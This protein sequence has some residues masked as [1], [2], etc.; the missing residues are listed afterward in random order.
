MSERKYNG[1]TNYATWNVK[2]WMDNDGSDQHW[3]DRAQELLDGTDED[4]SAD[5]RKSEAAR[6]LADEIEAAHIEATPELSGCFADILGSAMSEVSW[7]EIAESI[8]SDIEVTA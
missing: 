3:C 8:L 7:Y 2:L 5:D 6:L 4:D 1:W